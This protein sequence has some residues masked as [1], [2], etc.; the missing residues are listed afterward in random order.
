MKYITRTV[1]IFFL[2]FST[3]FADQL[4]IKVDGKSINLPYWPTKEK[5]YGAVLLVNG[6]AQ[7]QSTSLLDNLA[8][9]LAQ[10]G[11]Q[12]VLLNNDSRVNTPWIKQFPEVIATLRKQ[13]NTRIVLL[14]YG[15][16]LKQTFDY[17]GKSPV[18]DIEG[19]VLLSA[20]DIPPSTDKKPELKMPIFDIVGQFDFDMTK[21]DMAERKKEF[22]LKKKNYLALEIPGAYH[23]YEYSRQLLF[24]FIHGWMVKLPEFQPK[25]PPVMYSYLV[26]IA[27]FF[28]NQM[29]Q[30]KASN[31]SGHFEQPL[32]ID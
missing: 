21:Q 16:Q 18:P 22:A 4:E 19:L 23:D 14:H 12:V 31:W 27:S 8:T 7:A 6:G 30:N 20:Y 28:Q 10:N 15:E 13:K 9:Q 32:E 29:A 25:S 1:L 2:L 5:K 24:S 26:P 3:V 11:W 17:L